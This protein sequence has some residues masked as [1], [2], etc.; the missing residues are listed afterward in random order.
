MTQHATRLAEGW[1]LRAGPPDGPLRW[2]LPRRRCAPSV[3]GMPSITHE[4][5]V[6]PFQHRPA[7]AAELLTDAL[8]V[9]LPAWR[10]AR[11]GAGDLTNPIPAEFRADAV[12]ELYDTTPPAGT[13]DPRP[14]QAVV[15]E[16][17]LDT[18]LRKHYSWPVYLSTLRARHECPTT[19]LVICP[20]AK[21]ATW[22]RQPIELGHPDWILTPLVLGPDQTPIITDPQHARRQPELTV[23]SALAH[24]A[25]PHHR[26][27]LDALVAALQTVPPDHGEIY[28]DVV[29][30]SLPEAARRY[31]E[32]LMSTGTYQFRSEWALRHINRGK[33]EGRT[34][35]RA[36][37]VLI[38]L[39]TRG[40]D[41]PEEARDRITGCTDLDQLDTW[42][43]HAVTA[44]SIDEVFAD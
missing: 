12:I 14:V 33:A 9:K 24:G 29:Y 2:L 10:H 31:L 13:V 44:T 28:H 34:E 1:P 4:G 42:L 30:A 15:L 21:A 25:D 23:V 6:Q 22:C 16:V 27:V 18:D 7:L 40:I 38:V 17:Q 8:D 5:L 19:L 26:H 35:G 41:V 11:L 36:E 32:R 39:T 37:D 43:R 3:P 20:T